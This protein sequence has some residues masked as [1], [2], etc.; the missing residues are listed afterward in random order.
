VASLLGSIEPH[1]IQHTLQNFGVLLAAV[2]VLWLILSRSSHRMGDLF[3]RFLLPRIS[4]DRVPHE[5][6]LLY[7]RGWGIQRIEVPPDSRVIGRRLRDLDLRARNVQVIAV[8][9][10]NDVHPIPDP[11]WRFEA[12]QHLIVYGQMKEVQGAFGPV[13]GDERRQREAQDS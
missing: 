6:L 12:R 5:E 1:D 2:I 9:E 7:K 10:D 4:A 11:D 3:R 8:E 13:T